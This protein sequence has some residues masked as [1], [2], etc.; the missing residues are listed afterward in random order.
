M[1]TVQWQWQWYKDEC[2]EGNTKPSVWG[3][4]RLEI[5]RFV[6]PIICKI[7]GHKHYHAGVFSNSSGKRNYFECKR[8]HKG[9]TEK[10]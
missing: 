9:Y 10:L 6:S 3:F 1:N 5:E 4:L 7:R 2:E 8:C